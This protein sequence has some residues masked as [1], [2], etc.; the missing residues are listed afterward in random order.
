MM[1]AVSPVHSD[2]FSSLCIVIVS[3]SIIVAVSIVKSGK[4]EEPVETVE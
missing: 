3:S 1:L 4:S 2:F